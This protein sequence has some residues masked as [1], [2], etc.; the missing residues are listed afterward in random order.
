MVVGMTGW[1][2]CHFGGKGDV[3]LKFS[4]TKIMSIFRS[5]IVLLAISY[6]TPFRRM[7]GCVPRIYIHKIINTIQSKAHWSIR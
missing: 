1:V 7:N 5:K 2:L 3:R 4:F 6:G